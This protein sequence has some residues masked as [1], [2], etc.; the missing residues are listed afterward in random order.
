MFRPTSADAGRIHSNPSSL[1]GSHAMRRSVQNSIFFPGALLLLM[2]GC[3]GGS[4]GGTQMLPPQP[5]FTLNVS[6]GSVTIAQGN[7][8]APV[9]FTVSGINGFTGSVSV[10]L[11]GIPSGV[12]SN[13]PSPFA[14]TVGQMTSVIFG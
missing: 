14:V 2:E 8:S 13:P 10:A 6:A 7:A 3:G 12:V 11:S 4:G 1:R 9:A 5:D